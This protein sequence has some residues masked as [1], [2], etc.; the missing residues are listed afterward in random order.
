MSLTGHNSKILRE[1]DKLYDALRIAEYYRGF[2]Y[3]TN[4]AKDY[5]KAARYFIEKID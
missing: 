2:V 3:D 5:L 1:F 4:A